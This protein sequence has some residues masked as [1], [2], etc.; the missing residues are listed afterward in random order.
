V[1]KT[2]YVNGKFLAQPTTGVQRYAAGVVDAW[3]EDLDCGRIDRSIYSVRLIV[4]KTDRKIPKYKHIEVVPSILGGR[5][6][7]QA[8]LPLRSGGGVLF[9]P[10]AAAPVFKARH[11]VTIHDA[12]VA[13][14]PEQYSRLFRGYY[15]T[16]YRSLGRSSVALFTDSCFSKQELHK[17]FSI[18]LEK[19][20]VLPVGCDHLMK[21]PPSSDILNRFALEPGKFILG[22]SSQSPIKNF[23]GLVRAWSLLGRPDLKLAIAGGANSRVF[24]DGVATQDRR[25]VRLGYVS[26]GELRSLYEAASVFVYPSFYE[27]FGLPPLEA[28]TCGCPVLVARSSSLPESCGDAALYCDP[29]SPADIAEKIKSLLDDPELAEKMRILGKRW[30]VQFTTQRTASLL[31]SEIQKYL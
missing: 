10:Y 7:E 23:D 2:L 17:Y 27:G 15:G 18:P 3:D 16:V 31:W 28:M 12:G 24:R 25:I 4:P 19:M 8:E 9:S 29:S 20:T 6:W 22:V 30:S 26:D 14:T 13:A 1:K 5:L 21:I 11:I